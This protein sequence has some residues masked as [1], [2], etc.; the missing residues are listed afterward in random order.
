MDR[1][2]LTFY[3]YADTISIYQD[4]VTMTTVFEFLKRRC[5]VCCYPPPL[6]PLQLCGGA[7]VC[8]SCCGLCGGGGADLPLPGLRGGGAG[9]RP[10]PAE[11]RS[12]SLARHH[13]GSALLLA[14][15]GR[16]VTDEASFHPSG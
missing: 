11:R 14:G 9:L 8:R 5:D 13:G 16:G 12:G 10:H 3:K 2:R 7:A 1:H 15:L 4:D 6:P